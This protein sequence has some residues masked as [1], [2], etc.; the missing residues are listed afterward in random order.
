MVRRRLNGVSGQV[1]LNFGRGAGWSYVTVGSGPFK[2]ESY[3]D[4]AVPD[5]LGT[6]TINF[7]GGARWFTRSHLAF[8]VDLR[9]YLTD[10]ATATTFT[11]AR[12]RK[13]MLLFS[14]GISVK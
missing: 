5:G 13:R 11:A 1:S 2:F 10:P 6:T 12:V 7:G 3:L 9:F 4:E 14:A 8:T